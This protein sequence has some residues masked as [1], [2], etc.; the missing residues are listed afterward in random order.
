MDAFPEQAIE[1][2][3]LSY[4]SNEKLEKNDGLY[5]ESTVAARRSL[6][7]RYRKVGNASA[8]KA[9]QE[10]DR[11]DIV[12]GVQSLPGGTTVDT[13]G[14]SIKSSSVM[15]EVAVPAS[16]SP[17]SLHEEEYADSM[18]RLYATRVL[19]FFRQST[20][21]ICSSHAPR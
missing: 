11:T 6:I 20:R 16:A 21:P 18:M 15:T 17:I 3:R 2:E 5:A 1:E 13:G 9:L 4:E 14:S 8:A 19:Q 7:V 10:L 12:G